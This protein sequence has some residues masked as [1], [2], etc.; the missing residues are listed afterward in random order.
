MKVWLVFFAAAVPFFR[1]PAEEDGFVLWASVTS[2]V[3]HGEFFKN[4]PDAL[5]PGL[6]IGTKLSGR[7]GSWEVGVGSHIHFGEVGVM[8]HELGHTSVE[9]E[10]D[11]RSVSFD[12]FV[13]YT[14]PW[15]PYGRWLFYGSLGFVSRVFTVKLDEFRVLRGSFGKKNKLMY[16][17]R[18]FGASLG[19]EKP[20]RGGLPP[21]NIGLSLDYHRAYAA[22][23]VDL[24]HLSMPDTVE[25]V[26]VDGYP[27]ALSICLNFGVAIF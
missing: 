27:Q 26:D 18:G 17:S 20:S 19:L 24:S 14:T 25:E 9:G 13:K 10:G 11:Y 8:V 15:K 23:L 12:P 22:R 4:R 1:C 21:M 5:S 3:R 16:F 2:V 7:R 6:G